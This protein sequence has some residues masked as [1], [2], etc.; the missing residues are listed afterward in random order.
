MAAKY[1]VRKRI[2]FEQKCIGARW[3]ET[4]MKW[5]VQLRDL[6]TGL[7]SEDDADVFMTGEGVLN[8]WKWPDI[9]GLLN[10][11]GTL[12]HSANWDSQFDPKVRISRPTIS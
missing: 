4:A 8:E 3:S 1:D 12:L 9:K 6:K 11:Q 2:R 7:C 10:F 5:F